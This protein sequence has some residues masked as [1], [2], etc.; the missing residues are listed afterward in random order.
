MK[1]L[2]EKIFVMQFTSFV[3]IAGRIGGYRS[4]HESI[5]A[6]FTAVGTKTGKDWFQPRSDGRYAVV[7]AD[8]MRLMTISEN[9]ISG[10][11]DVDVALMVNDSMFTSF[12]QLF[13]EQIMAMQY[14]WHIKVLD[15]CITTI[16]KIPEPVIEITFPKSFS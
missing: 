4:T 10:K 13:S 9:A 14:A 7:H 16:K 5:S 3:E 12:Y 2:M 15:N 11:L 8:G 1:S 6:L